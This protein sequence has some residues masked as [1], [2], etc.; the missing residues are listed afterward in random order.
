LILHAIGPLRQNQARELRFQSG[1]GFFTDRIPAVSSA[2]PAQDSKFY[3][4][5]D[6]EASPFYKLITHYFG[7]IERENTD[8]IRMWLS[9]AGLWKEPAARAPPIPP[10]PPPRVAEPTVDYEFFANTCS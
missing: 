3:R 6:P 1:F 10:E 7:L 9:A 8:L 4:R 5:R 2:E